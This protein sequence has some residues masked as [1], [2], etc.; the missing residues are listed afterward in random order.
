MSF[1]LMSMFT[2]KRQ[3][4]KKAGY[5]K[6]IAHPPVQWI[7]DDVDNKRFRPLRSMLPFS[8][9]SVYLSVGHVHALCSNG[10]AYRLRDA[11]CHLANMIDKAAVYCAGAGSHYVLSDV[12]FCQIILAIV[13]ACGSATDTV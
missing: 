2:T 6:Q 3:T 10:S 12:A 5:R 7:L 9:L 13:T 4:N 8:G 11:C 1:V